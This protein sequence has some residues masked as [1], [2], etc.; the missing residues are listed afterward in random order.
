[1]INTKNCFE[2][3]VLEDL[4]SYT[5]IICELLIAEDFCIGLANVRRIIE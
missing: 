5:E 3:V 2:N 4:I 1:M